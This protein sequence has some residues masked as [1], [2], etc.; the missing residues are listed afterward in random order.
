MA[1]NPHVGDQ[2][3]PANRGRQPNGPETRNV[4]STHIDP[5]GRVIC[6][7]DAGVYCSPASQ[8]GH[9]AA[10]WPGLFVGPWLNDRRA[11]ILRKPIQQKEHTQCGCRR[12]AGFAGVVGPYSGDLRQ[13]GARQIHL[14]MKQCRAMFGSRRS[15]NARVVRRTGM[16]DRMVVRYRDWSGFR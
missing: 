9:V 3:G 7:C 11:V 14:A 8:P 4:K 1:R 15:P 12:Y 2:F 16:I 5:R 6:S 10:S 13:I